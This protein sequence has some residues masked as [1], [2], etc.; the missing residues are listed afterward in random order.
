MN[1]II[2]FLLIILNFTVTA[3]SKIIFSRSNG[4]LNSGTTLDLM[5]YDPI[6]KT[7]KLLLKGT[8]KK[9]GEYNAVVSPDYTKIIFNTYQ[10]GGW[11]IAI[12]DFKEEQITNV[13]KLTNRSNYEYC[14]KYSP[15]GSKIVY[16]EYNWGTNGAT[17]YIADKN[18]K[19]AKPF[20]KPNISDQNL[21]WTRDNKSIVFTNAKSKYLSIYIK[22]I[23]GTV[24]KKISNHNANNFAPSTS[25]VTDKIAF[26]SD[27]TGKIDLF[28]MDIDGENI[29][30]LTPNLKT[31]DT[32]VN[33]IW[34]Y[35]TSWSPDGKQ[36]V[37][38]ALINGNLE[39]FIVNADGTALNQITENNDSDI[40][41]FWIN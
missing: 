41:P 16:Q 31:S 2:T 7:T 1:F 6:Q 18:G 33:N 28:V 25:K 11:K 10:F 14:A 35:K 40:T 17:I 15:D 34:A 36:I 3:Q 4:T 21:D 19:N 8:V 20:F 22:S 27:K 24:V 13:K 38:N 39:L 30:N 5:I 9:R 32:D 26:L 12:G 37:F 23:D 29:T